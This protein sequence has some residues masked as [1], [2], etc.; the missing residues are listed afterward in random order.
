[1]KI[2]GAGAKRAGSFSRLRQICGRDEIGARGREV[3]SGEDAVVDLRARRD[4]CWEHGMC[5]LVCWGAWRSPGEL[6]PPIANR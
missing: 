5:G 1:M 3:M 2:G 6:L 4:P